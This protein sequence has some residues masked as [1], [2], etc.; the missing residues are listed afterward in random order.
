MGPRPLVFLLQLQCRSSI[1]VTSLGDTIV[2]VRMSVGIFSSQELSGYEG[3]CLVASCPEAKEEKWTDSGKL[4]N[5]FFVVSG[6]VKFDEACVFVN[7]LQ[8][9]YHYIEETGKRLAC[10]RSFLNIINP[11]ILTFIN[12]A[13]LLTIRKCYVNDVLK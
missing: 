5:K 9:G 4:P 1:R 13:L 12:H 3:V 6:I 7:L 11:G 10:F 8:Y 2:I